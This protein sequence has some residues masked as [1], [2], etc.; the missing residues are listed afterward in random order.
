MV[1]G[2]NPAV[3]TIFLISDQVTF[4]Q[5]YDGI[6]LIIRIAAGGQA[7]F[8]LVLFCRADHSV[9]L[10]GLSLAEDY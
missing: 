6:C 9:F 8:E 3:P 4:R 7:L 2:S 5:T 1:V 10:V